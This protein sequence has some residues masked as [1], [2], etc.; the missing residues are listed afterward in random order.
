MDRDYTSEAEREVCFCIGQVTNSD[1]TFEPVYL[2]QTSCDADYT[3]FEAYALGRVDYYSH[4]GEATVV[5]FCRVREYDGTYARSVGTAR[6]T[7]LEACRDKLQSICDCMRI[8]YIGDTA[9]QIHYNLGRYG[10]SVFHGSIFGDGTDYAAMVGQKG[11]QDVLLNSQS[12]SVGAYLYSR[13]V[14]MQSDG[15]I[16]YNMDVIREVMARPADSITD[17]EYEAVALAYFHMSDADMAELVKMCTVKT[18]DMHYGLDIGSLADYINE[19]YSEWSIDSDKHSRLLQEMNLL[20]DSNLCSICVYDG[21]YRD[22]GDKD[23]EARA[24]ALYAERCSYVQR[25]ALFDVLGATEGLRADYGSEYPDIMITAVPDRSGEVSYRVQYREFKDIGSG[26]FHTYSNL[27][28][29]TITVKPCMYS[30]ANMRQQ[31][32]D[33]CASLSSHFAQGFHSEGFIDTE[34]RVQFIAQHLASFAVNTSGTYVMNQLPP[35]AGYMQTAASALFGMG[36]DYMAGVS[37]AQTIEAE[38]EKLN[39]AKLYETFNCDVTRIEYD[40]REIKDTQ[41]YATAGRYTVASITV[42]NMYYP[43]NPV[44]FDMIRNNPEKIAGDI[45]KYIEEENSEGIN[46]AELAGGKY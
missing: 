24:D 8:P 33:T 44:T 22:Y 9:E 26:V 2:S 16:V 30:D 1:L 45:D 46:Q 39:I 27:A 36:A 12:E 10:A 5:C 4:M 25:T 17:S 19:D 23:Y 13:I 42:Y 35:Y 18:K 7:R 34:A 21:L 29:S 14:M 41:M 11:F 32:K 37:N 43:D 40:T 15:S 31:I 3:K 38:E 20:L 6:T 28:P